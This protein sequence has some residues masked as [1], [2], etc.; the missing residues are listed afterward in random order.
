M[1]ELF[2]LEEFWVPVQYVKA[3]PEALKNASLAAQDLLQ[4]KVG[5]TRYGEAQSTLEQAEILLAQD[6]DTYHSLALRLIEVAAVREGNVETFEKSNKRNTSGKHKGP[7]FSRGC[8]VG[9]VLYVRKSCYR[10]C[11]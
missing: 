10:N 8:T 9:M 5:S 1:V 7:G 3:K 2:S 11:C 4:R 6:S